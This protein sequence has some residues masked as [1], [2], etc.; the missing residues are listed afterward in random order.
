MVKD[1]VIGFMPAWLFC[2]PQLW[3]RRLKASIAGA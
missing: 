3:R 1:P 2:V